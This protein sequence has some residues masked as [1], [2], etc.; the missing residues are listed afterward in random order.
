MKVTPLVLLVLASAACG[1]APPPARAPAATDPAA[2]QQQLLERS[3]L[4]VYALLGLREELELTSA[5]VVALDS[6]GLQLQRRN[7][8]ISQRLPAPGARP[9]RGVQVDTAALRQLR[10]NRRAAATGVQEVLT[11][12]QQTRVC[13]IYRRRDAQTRREVRQQPTTRGGVLLTRPPVWP[14][15]VA[16]TAAS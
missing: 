1:S 10:E 13:E 11:E 8:P 7:T 16:T 15:C 3:D 4:P 12:A 5:Q 2:L 9:T 6:I 14:W